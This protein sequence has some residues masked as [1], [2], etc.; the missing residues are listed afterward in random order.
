MTREQMATAEII[1]RREFKYLIDEL[2][3]ARVR[4]AIR[5]FCELDPHAAVQPSGRYLIDNCYFDNSSFALYRANVISLVDRYKVRVRAYPPHD[6]GP[7]FLEVKSRGN[8]VISKSRAPVSRDIWASLVAE[9]FAP[10]PPEI[11]GPQ[12]A[13]VEKFLALVQINHLRPVTLVRYEREPHVSRV[14]AYARVTIDR[15]VRNKALTRP[16]FD[17]GPGGGAGWTTPCCSGWARP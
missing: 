4:E 11:S 10:I 6:D 17:A 1:E 12:R 16:S 14:D 7:L 5:P 13:A 3:A 8:D 15:S 9:P 2:T